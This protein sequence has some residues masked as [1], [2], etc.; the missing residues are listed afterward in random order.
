MTAVELV[1][2][3]RDGG[4]LSAEEIA[5]LVRGIVSGAVS[6]A[7]TGAFLMA[8]YLRGLSQD[9]TVALTLEMAHS[10][11]MLDLSRIPGTVD[12]HST[13]GVGD[14]TTLVVAPL[15][16]AAG[17][18]VPKLSG[19]ALG[20]T[21][22]TVDRWQAIPGFRTDLTTEAFI[23]QLTE[24]GVAVGGHTSRLA[25][26][27]KKLY[28]LRDQTATVDSVSLIAASVMSKKLA[29][30]AAAIL[31]DV[32]CGRGAFVT[33]PERA[34]ELAMTMVEI[35]Q[36][37][38]RRMCALITA[39][40]QPLGKAVGEGIEMAEAIETLQGGGPADFVELCLLVGSQMVHLGGKAES[41]EAARPVLEELLGSGAAYAK[42]KQMVAA[43]GGNLA[44]LDAPEELG[45]A[46]HERLIK[47]DRSGFIQEIN[48]HVIG[49]VARGLVVNHRG[50][51]MVE[52]KVGDKVAAGELL[53][54]L[55]TDMPEKLDE[56]ACRVEAAYLIGEGKPVAASV[57]LCPAI[58]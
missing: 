30:G 9:E 10:G 23:A 55:L 50:G 52:H 27:D 13:G 4:A 17:V 46:K 21:G 34:K 26:A 32:K 47:A 28:A 45:R 5:F 15:V 53:A 7:Q 3:K 18:P 51:I 44:V 6:E 43:Q 24:I 42:F 1:K 8:A 38:G 2:K 11:E 14:K 54:T 58:R 36:A 12:K 29:C 31:L 25:P 39:M 35:G 40:D 49:E 19:G 22:G 48:A 37:A 56:A 57:L 16:A 20:H 41:P 33:D